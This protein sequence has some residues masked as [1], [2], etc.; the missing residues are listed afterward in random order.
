MEALDGSLFDGAV[1]ALNLTIRPGM[2]HLGQPMLDAVFVAGPIEDVTKV[3]DVAGAVGELNSVVF[4]YGM[5]CIRN[6][7]DQIAQELGCGHLACLCVQ[8]D[9]GKLGRPVDGDKEVELAL[10]GLNLS[11]I[12]VKI[13]DRV[14]LEFF[15]G[16]LVARDLW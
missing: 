1:H 2:F 7:F 5:D 3:V 13:A 15:L 14:R 11:N 6:G 12:N 10:G 4:Q 8:F 9:V 16:R